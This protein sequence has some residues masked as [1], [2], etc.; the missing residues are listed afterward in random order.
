MHVF[1]TRCKSV[2]NR[3]AHSKCGIERLKQR[4]LA[5]WLEQALHRALFEQA[6]PG[7][8][9][10]VSSDENDRNRLPAK[11]QFS[12]KIGSGHARHRDVEDQTSRL[13]DAIRGEELFSR[14]ERPGR[15]AELPQQVG[16]RLA[17]RLVVI[18]YRYEQA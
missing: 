16:K 6:W 9:V 11:H 15:K 5:E 4:R 13:I 14:R 10:F 2:A 18:D 8:L 7:G 1:P 17:H 12:L 3:S